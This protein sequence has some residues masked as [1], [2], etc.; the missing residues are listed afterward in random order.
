[1]RLLFYCLLCFTHI[2]INMSANDIDKFQTNLDSLLKTGDEKYL[3]LQNNST[4]WE[5]VRLL[6]GHQID[7][8][9]F[10]RKEAE[11]ILLNYLKT[12]LP[13]F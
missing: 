4:Q 8:N 3:N 9:I 12:G 7:E 6:Y 5:M 1:M 10:N 13:L 2:S 11:E